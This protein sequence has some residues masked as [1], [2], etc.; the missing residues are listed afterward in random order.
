MP[1]PGVVA[2]EESIIRTLAWLPLSLMSGV[3]TWRIVLAVQGLGLVTLLDVP[4]PGSHYSGDWLL[5]F[6]SRTPAWL[7]HCWMQFANF[8]LL[9]H[10]M[11][12]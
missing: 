10:S 4:C 3:L 2:S 11:Q 8:T 6:G 9:S 5:D 7:D 1:H 12:V